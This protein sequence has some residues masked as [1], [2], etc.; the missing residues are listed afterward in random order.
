MKFAVFIF[1]V[2]FSVIGLAESNLSDCTRGLMS[3]P[4]CITKIN[5][6]SFCQKMGDSVDAIAAISDCFQQLGALTQNKQELTMLCLAGYK[7]SSKASD[8]KSLCEES[9]K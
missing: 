6:K 8:N 5:A 7:T 4:L 9:P 1:L 3:Q 2:T